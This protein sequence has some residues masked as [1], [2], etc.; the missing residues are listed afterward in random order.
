MTQWSILSGLSPDMQRHV[1]SQLRRRRYA[2]HEVL[3]HEGDPGNAMHLV[4]SGRLAVRIESLSGDPVIV[5]VIGPGAHVGE[6]ALVNPSATRTASVVALDRA[7]TLVLDHATFRELCEAH[8]E[9]TSVLIAALAERVDG[10]SRDVVEAYNVPATKRVIRRL[11]RVAALGT[12]APSDGTSTP[13]EVPITQD[14]LAAMAGTTRPTVNKVLKAA[15]QRG[16]LA[17]TRGRV[18]IV[19]HVALARR[20]R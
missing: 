11:L 10:L 3:F 20:A 8:H 14:D 9:V 4:A 15:E 12:E 18:C 16:E 6:L 19:D 1:I 2:R 7:E 13:I 5:N 17:V